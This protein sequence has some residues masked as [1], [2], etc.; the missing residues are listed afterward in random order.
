MAWSSSLSYHHFFGRNGGAV[1]LFDRIDIIVSFF[2]GA[3]AVFLLR[4]LKPEE[5]VRWLGR[6]LLL[7]A[8]QRR[9]RAL[10]LLDTT[11]RR[12]RRARA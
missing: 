2:G 8:V 6:L 12:R 5:V 9:G 11:P 3:S 4:P 10:L 7:W 1:S